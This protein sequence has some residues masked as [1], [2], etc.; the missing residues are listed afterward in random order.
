MLLTKTRKKQQGDPPEDGTA[1]LSKDEN[2]DFI[3]HRL[4]TIRKT[5]SSHA[6]KQDSSD[7]DLEQDYFSDEDKDADEEKKNLESNYQV[8]QPE[9]GVNLHGGML[10]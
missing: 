3:F 9:Q 1:A 8:H 7:N 2:G 4:K 6:V 5:K 10:L